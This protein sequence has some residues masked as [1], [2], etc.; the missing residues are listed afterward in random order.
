LAIQV[1]HNGGEA[2]EKKQRDESLALKFLKRIVK[3][4]NKKPQKINPEI[5]GVFFRLEKGSAK[6]PHSP[7]KP[8]QTHHQ[9]TTFGHH[10]FLKTPAKTTNSPIPTITK[11]ITHKSPPQ[12][13]AN[14]LRRPLPSAI[15]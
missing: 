12:A 9:K 2:E 4:K 1:R 13:L 11:K 6:A 5:H 8:P 7:R 3:P 14:P 15:H 10:F